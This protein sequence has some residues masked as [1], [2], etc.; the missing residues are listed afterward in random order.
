MPKGNRT[1]HP[2]RAGIKVTPSKGHDAILG[3]MRVPSEMLK[4]L[5]AITEKLGLSRA[6]WVKAKVQEDY[7][8]LFGSK[9]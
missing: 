8:R 5:D 4:Q 2:S 7:E 9:V 3:Q 1:N 6:E